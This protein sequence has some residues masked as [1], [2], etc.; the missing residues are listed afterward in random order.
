MRENLHT[1]KTACLLRVL[2]EPFAAPFFDYI[3][4]T[5]AELTC[6]CV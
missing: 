4:G 6:Y 5:S 1:P 3:A 2:C